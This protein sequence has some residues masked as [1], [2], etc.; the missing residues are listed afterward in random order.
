MYAQLFVQEYRTAAAPI[1]EYR[2]AAAIAA[3]Q[4]FE[5][6]VNDECYNTRYYSSLPLS[7]E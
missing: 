4:L 7:T 1:A 3:I 2:T 6:S 5:V